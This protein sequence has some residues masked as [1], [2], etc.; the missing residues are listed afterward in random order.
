MRKRNLLVMLCVLLVA[1]VGAYAAES[2]GRF[3]NHIVD[4]METELPDG[5]KAVVL[6]YYQLLTSDKADDPLNNTASDCVGKLILSKDGKT[7]SGSGS[8]FSRD[9]DGDGMS[10]WWKVDEAG[11]TKC[12]DLCGSFGSFDAFGKYKGMTS[13]G[14]WVRTHVFTD[15]AIGTFKQTYMKK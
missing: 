6:H 5:R 11:T 14:T 15:G 10:R 3:T 7:L 1:S 12:P 4:T 9:V 13:S 2:M 8:C